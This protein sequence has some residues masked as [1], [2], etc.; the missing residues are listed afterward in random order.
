MFVRVFRHFLPVSII[1][2]A[3]L[4]ILLITLSWHLFLS[5]DSLWS[6]RLGNIL[7]SS[8]LPVAIIAG[9][10]MVIS[11]LYQRKTFYD[12]R[13]LT[14]N[15]LISLVFI[16]PITGII[17]LYGE[18]SFGFSGSLWELYLKAAGSW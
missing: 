14:I 1:V 5:P 12:Y 16:C 11:G 7:E 10:F 18:R 6:L 4:E 8:M 13:V 15:V 3:L 2:L 9:A 17:Y